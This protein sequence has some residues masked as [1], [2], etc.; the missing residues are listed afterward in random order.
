MCF[1]S[2]VLSNS[3]F[4]G[5][6]GENTDTELYPRDFVFRSGN[7]PP[8]PNAICVMRMPPMCGHACRYG[9]GDYKV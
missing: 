4:G 1:F 7:L 6:G 8:L 3:A 2:H 9:N 5:L